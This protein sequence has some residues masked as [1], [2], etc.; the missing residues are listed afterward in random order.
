[1]DIPI[2]INN[3]L[4]TSLS[5]AQDILILKKNSY[6]DNFKIKTM[7]CYLTFHFCDYQRNWTFYISFIVNH[8]LSLYLSW[9][10]SHEK[11]PPRP[12]TLKSVA[13]FTLRPR[14]LGCFLPMTACGVRWGYWGRPIP[15]R[16]RTPLL[17]DS[18]SPMTFWPFL[19]LEGSLHPLSPSLMPSPPPACWAP[20]WF[21][22][23]QAVPL[24]LW[25]KLCSTQVRI[26]KS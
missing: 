17:T 2:Y 22:F 13:L 23:T 9:C 7:V 4:S 21:P 20:S 18:D 25:V 12:P 10:G 5:P 19:R 16:H 6:S 14:L 8:P 26:L 11:V 1:M 15:R 3:S 24:M